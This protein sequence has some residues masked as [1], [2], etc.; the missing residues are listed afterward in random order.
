MFFRRIH[1]NSQSVF[2]LYYKCQVHNFSSSLRDKSHLPNLSN[3][4]TFF[5]P[6]IATLFIKKERKQSTKLEVYEVSNLSMSVAECTMS[7]NSS[8]STMFKFSNYHGVPIDCDPFSPCTT[9]E[10]DNFKRKK[11]MPLKRSTEEAN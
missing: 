1:N 10:C 4:T 11:N 8:R 9:L 5:F 2:F 7:V 6:F 3:S